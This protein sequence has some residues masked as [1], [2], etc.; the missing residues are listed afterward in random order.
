MGAIADGIHCRPGAHLGASANQVGSLFGVG[1][2]GL[3]RDHQHV[4]GLS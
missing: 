1:A 3:Q 4:D 2:H